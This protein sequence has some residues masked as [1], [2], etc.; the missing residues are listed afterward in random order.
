TSSTDLAGLKGGGEETSEGFFFSPG[1]RSNQA[2]TVRSPLRHGQNFSIASRAIIVKRRQAVEKKPSAI[3]RPE[4]LSQVRCDTPVLRS[5][6]DTLD[7][8]R[9]TQP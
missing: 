1:A 3:S 2:M 5:T 6:E 4:S 7:S 8:P 9:L